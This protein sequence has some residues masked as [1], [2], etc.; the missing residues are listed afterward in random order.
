MARL[1]SS[2]IPVLL[3]SQQLAACGR[4][5]CSRR[6]FRPKMSQVHEFSVVMTCDGCSG[7]VNR[8]LGRVKEV[9]KIDIDMEA[10]KVCV[11]STLS[12]E[13]LLATLKK[14]GRECAYIGTK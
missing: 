13:E 1:L 14:T 8:V 10:Q 4:G 6:G 9:T 12:G 3:R 2:M 5:L 7:A 11:E